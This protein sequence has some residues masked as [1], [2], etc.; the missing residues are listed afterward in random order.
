MVFSRVQL[1]ACALA[2]TFMGVASA[3]AQE[4]NFN[5][6]PGE[7][8][9]SIP[10]LARQAGVQI[11]APGSELH[12]VVTPEVKGRME[13]KAALRTMLAKTSLELA[14]ED[15]RVFVLRKAGAAPN[16]GAVLA[17]STG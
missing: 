16:E 5:I 3:R 7:A 12:A 1:V 13:F 10:E 15:G 2:L 8:G 14:A 4:A 9:K 17:P 11:I 6:P